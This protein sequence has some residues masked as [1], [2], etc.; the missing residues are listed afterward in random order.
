MQAEEIKLSQLIEEI[1]IKLREN[2]GLDY[3]MR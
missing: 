3:D 2:T 1:E